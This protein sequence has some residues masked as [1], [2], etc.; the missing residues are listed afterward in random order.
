MDAFN[1]HWLS[2]QDV[3]VSA[4]VTFVGS[5][6]FVIFVFKIAVLSDNGERAV[7]FR[8]PPPEQCHPDWKGEILRQPS[9]KVFN[10]PSL[11]FAA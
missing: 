3:P 2:Q 11:F 10:Y 6:A 4:L 5:I 7:N 9:L 8:V 1:Q